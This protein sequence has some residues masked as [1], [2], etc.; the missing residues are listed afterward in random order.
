[1]NHP[2]RKQAYHL[3]IPRRD[4]VLYLAWEVGVSRVRRI[5]ARLGKDERGWVDMADFTILRQGERW[6]RR[7]LESFAARIRETIAYQEGRLRKPYTAGGGLVR[8]S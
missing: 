2:N 7:E 4:A 1:M 8:V 3:Y 5:L 6:T